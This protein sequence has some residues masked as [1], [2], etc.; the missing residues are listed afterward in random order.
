[1]EVSKNF[2]GQLKKKLRTTSSCGSWLL[3]LFLISCQTMPMPD[4][5]NLL[6][7]DAA[8]IPL[9]TGADIYLFADAKDAR[10]IIELLPI[11]ELKDNQAKQ[12]L[13][14][15]D[16]VAAAVFPAK[17]GRQFQL[18]A[19]GRYPASQAGAALNSNKNWEKLT[20]SKGYVYWYSK[21]SDLSM[22][23]NNKQAFVVSTMNKKP[24]EPL[25]VVPG[26]EI[27]PGFNEF[28]RRSPFSC[29]IDNPA[30]MMVKILS[31]A[32]IPVRFPVQKVFLNLYPVKEKFEAI[33]R[34]QFENAS[35][36]RG[37]AAIL[38]LAGGF[39]SNGQDLIAA[40]LLANPPVL[41]DASLDI[42]TAALGEKDLSLL[43]EMFLLY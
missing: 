37:V 34:L 2:I 6:S 26:K 43:L 8:H 23:L 38:N 10:S 20:A 16:F 40:L 21:G 31:E 18:T 4:V 11:K 33:I 36:A 27:P 32:G 30:P 22:T 41:N 42:K 12:M 28:R 25:A 17:S 14:R 7:D 5:S 19:W 13:N 1:M 9:D 3:L 15:T 29:W 24:E 39:L 35:Q